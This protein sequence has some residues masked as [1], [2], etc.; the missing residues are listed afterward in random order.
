V[1]G[2]FLGFHTNPGGKWSKDC[3]VLDLEQAKVGDLNKYLHSF[4]VGEVYMKK[5]TFPAAEIM[6]KHYGEQKKKA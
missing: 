4:R 3:L 2:I 1:P 5:I 6:Q